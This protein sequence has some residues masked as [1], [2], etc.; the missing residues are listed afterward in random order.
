MLATHYVFDIEYNSKANDVLLF[1]QEKVL[2][3]PDPHVKK[4]SVYL[5]TVAGIECYCSVVTDHIDTTESVRY[6]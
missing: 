2:G 6:W 1:L 3:L 5:S 4:S